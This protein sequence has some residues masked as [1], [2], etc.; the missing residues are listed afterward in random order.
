MK[1]SP[2]P[3]QLTELDRLMAELRGLDQRVLATENTGPLL[4]DRFPAVA[5]ELD[6]CQSIFERDGFFGRHPHPSIQ[7]DQ[8]YRAL[9]GA[10]S[11][12]GGRNFLIAAGEA[13]LKRRFEERK[14]VGMTNAAREMTLRELRLQRRRSAATLEV[15]W[16]HMEQSGLMVT[17]P[18]DLVDVELF[19]SDTASLE[20][21]ASGKEHAT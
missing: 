21:I 9:I 3:A 12:A 2:N 1:S 8:R 6:E 16:R 19:L 13:R 20:R 7:A 17:R 18:E 4:E 5:A 14:E 15:F 10:L 11:I